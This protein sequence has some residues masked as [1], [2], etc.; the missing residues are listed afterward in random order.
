MKGVCFAYLLLHLVLIGSVVASSPKSNKYDGYVMLQARPETEFHL[1]LLNKLESG[2]S[3]EL[4]PPQP[5]LNKDC[6]LL[7]SPG[8]VDEVLSALES[9]AGLEFHVKFSNVGEIIR[10]QQVASSLHDGR[11]YWDEYYNLDA[12]YEFL[13]EQ[14]ALHPTLATLESIGT[15]YE[16]R[17]LDMIIIKNDVGTLPKPIIYLETNIHAREWITS[18]V[19]TYIIDQLLN[20]PADV[21]GWVDS[22]DFYILP[23]ANPD[24]F[25]YTHQSDRLWRKTRSVTTTPNA[26][27][28]ADPNRNFDAFWMQ[29]GGASPDPCNQ[30]FAGLSPFSEPEVLAMAEFMNRTEINANMVMYMSLHSSGQY[31][32]IPT[33]LDEN[34]IPEYD[35]YMTIANDTAAAHTAVYGKNYT[36][37]SIFELM[38]PATGS[39]LDWAYLFVPNAKFHVTYELRDKGE[40]GFLLPPRQILPMCIE[41]MAGF[42]VTL[43]HLLRP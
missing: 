14:V 18:A 27:M 40:Y 12:I 3:L 41:F 7:I 21:R 29:N 36:A 19:S 11:L 20:G 8:K 15:T 10:S 35:A 30:A 5:K 9:A 34:K 24:G 22:F 26:C 13:R 39:S 17:S 4:M 42:R 16:N 38:Y 33:G 25:S 43:D 1:H 32:L 2:G 31:L 23:V 37:G 28:G 6:D